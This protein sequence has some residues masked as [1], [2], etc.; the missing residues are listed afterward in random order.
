VEAVYI[1]GL[2]DLKNKKWPEAKLEFESLLRI[3]V[4]HLGALIHLGKTFALLG[5]PEKAAENFQK[6]LKADKDSLQAQEAWVEFCF[7]DGDKELSLPYLTAL[8]NKAVADINLE[9]TAKFSRM[10]IQLKPALVPPQLQLI[11]A[12]QAL[13]DFKGAAEA[14]Q[15]LAL[16]YEQQEQW[17]EAVQCLEKALNL[18]PANSEVL[19]KSLADIIEKA[20][21]LQALTQPP[22]ASANVIEV[23]IE[24]PDNSDA[25]VVRFAEIT[26]EESVESQPLPEPP[27]SNGVEAQMSTAG[28]C[29][30]HGLLKAAIHIYQ[31]ILQEN[32]ELTEIRAKLNEVN[33]AYLKQWMQS[34]DNFPS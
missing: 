3:K 30:Q 6:A 1:L 16:V 9:Q 20:P 23:T 15:A 4:N 5:Q 11:E 17:N 22:P 34:K 31:Q 32:P 12:L 8:L 10:M 33:A 29:I 27:I 28:L 13:G 19:K 2:I 25:D 26:E 21:S 24:V 18:N 7:L 14:C